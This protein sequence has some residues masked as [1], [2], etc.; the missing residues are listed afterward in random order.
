M[1]IVVFI[2][3]L[4]AMLKTMGYAIFEIKEK[5]NKAG[6][7]TVFL[8]SVIRICASKFSGVV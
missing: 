3:T 4:Y 2:L 1:K 8:I 5:N 6:G 7:I